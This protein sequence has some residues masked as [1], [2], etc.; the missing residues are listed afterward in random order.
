MDEDA[1][2]LFHRGDLA[3]AAALEHQAHVQDPANENY[4]VVA[5]TMR[6]LLAGNRGYADPNAPVTAEAHR[7]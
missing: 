5:Y 1:R 2:L 4:R 7:N 3:G 6:Q